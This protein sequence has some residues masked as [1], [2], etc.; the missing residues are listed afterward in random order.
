[1]TI[2]SFAPRRR[3][4]I[5]VRIWLAALVGA[6]L[7][8]LAPLLAR[9][10]GAGA[11]SVTL[12]WT[13]PGD[14]GSI[15]TATL[16]HMKMSTSTITSGNWASATDVSGLP[17]PL[18]SGTRQSVVVRGLSSGTTYYFAIRAEDDAGNLAPIS[19]VVQWNWVYDTAP[20]AAPS[21]VSAA[22]AGANVQVSWSANSEPDLQGYSVYRATASSGPYSKISSSVLTGLSYVDT[23]VPAGVSSV[24][25]EVTA[26]DNSDNESARSAAAQVQLSSAPPPTVTDALSAA[27]P[28]PSKRGDA[29]CLPITSAGSGD[30]MF[31]DI[32]SS[33][34]FRV[35]RLDVASAPRC[36]DGSVR[37]DGHNDAGVEVAPGV[38]RAWLI[39]GDR[40]SAIKLVRQP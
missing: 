5:D 34:G 1:M 39:A 36:T 18:V 2:G 9:A 32:I 15:G 28:N 30:G 26:T 17:S 21:G 29:V 37:W 25:Y 8:L 3:R 12:Q 40:K 14:D 6:A 11:D 24:W 10:Q 33:G 27:Y 19:N 22:K 13:A 4:R 38:Y 23:A 31:I 7:V 20:P 16:Y 35:R